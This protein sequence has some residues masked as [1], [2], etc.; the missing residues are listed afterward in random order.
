MNCAHC[1]DPAKTIKSAHVHRLRD[2]EY[3][4]RL[5]ACEGIYYLA[6]KTNEPCCVGCWSEI[7]LGR[8]PPLDG[9]RIGG[10]IGN[11]RVREDASPADENAA[12]ALEDRNYD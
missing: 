6:G 10:N 9:S 4:S 2:K 12:R 5:L 1:G 7:Y 8:I 3:A 11:N